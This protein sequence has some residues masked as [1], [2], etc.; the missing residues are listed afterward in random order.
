MTLD[1]I[2]NDE[3]YDGDDDDEDSHPVTYSLNRPASPKDVLNNALSIPTSAAAAAA[4][5]KLV[6][7]GGGASEDDD[8]N[9]SSFVSSSPKPYVASPL[10]STT[11]TIN[12][13]S[14]PRKKESMAIQMASLQASFAEKT[15]EEMKQIVNW[16]NSTS[17]STNTTTNTNNT[18]GNEQEDRFIKVPQSRSLPDNPLACL[19][20]D[21][22]DDEKNKDGDDDPMN[23]HQKDLDEDRTPQRTNRKKINSGDDDDDSSFERRAEIRPVQ[24]TPKYS[25]TG[26]S[27]KKED[28]SSMVDD[29]PA[30]TTSPTMA[31]SP[32]S[33]PPVDKKAIR[34]STPHS[35]NTT[36][37]EAQKQHQ[38]VK[39]LLEATQYMASIVLEY[40]QSSSA[41]DREV[42]QLPITRQRR[43]AAAA[44]SSNFTVQESMSMPHPSEML[45]DRFSSKVKKTRTQRRRRRRLNKT[46]RRSLIMVG[47]GMAAYLV[48]ML[49][50]TIRGRMMLP[51]L[52]KNTT[53]MIGR[54]S[55]ETDQGEAKLLATLAAPPNFNPSSQCHQSVGTDREIGNADNGHSSPDQCQQ[56]KKIGNEQQQQVEVHS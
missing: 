48:C 14:S 28:G 3:N 9:S 16:Y 15:A 46:L 38:V 11:A 53:P 31:E 29:L 51:S 43:R 2:L 19:D 8:E 26:S 35:S 36:S 52:E 39:D 40:E 1:S 25:G 24:T 45:P 41:S 13:N 10:D 23:R 37:R 54:D 4:A 50:L 33:I 21:D 42:S 44:P 34:S 30:L 12:T 20:D 5:L 22:E 47:V 17:S 18:N 49:L 6:H 56:V 55:L 32:M 7:A 27:N